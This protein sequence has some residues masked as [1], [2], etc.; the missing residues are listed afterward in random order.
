M[1]ARQAQILGSELDENLLQ[2]INNPIFFNSLIGDPNLGHGYDMDGH[3]VKVDGPKK[4][5]P[6]FWREGQFD[7]G[8]VYIVAHFAAVVNGTPPSFC[9]QCQLSTRPTPPEHH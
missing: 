3:Q 7:R 2:K 5:P 9:H 8:G 4:S 6:R 1:R